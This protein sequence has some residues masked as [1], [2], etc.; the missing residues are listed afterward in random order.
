MHEGGLGLRDLGCFN[1]A[2]LAKK[3]WRLLKN[4]DSLVARVLLGKYCWRK[5]MWDCFPE[6]RLLLGVEKYIVGT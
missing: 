3:A 2:L 1:Q 6:V 5:A 4:P